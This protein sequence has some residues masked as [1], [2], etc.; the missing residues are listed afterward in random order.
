MPT[1]YAKSLP[2]LVDTKDAVDDRTQP[3]FAMAA[4]IS[5]NIAR[6]PT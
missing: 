4:F 5:S 3:A 6:E 1:A 2:H